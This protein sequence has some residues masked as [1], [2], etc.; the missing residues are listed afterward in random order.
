MVH[1][2]A[3]RMR[4]AGRGG[5]IINISATGSRSVSSARNFHIVPYNVSKAGLD[6]FT[7]Y[8]AVALGDS[9]VRVN[10]IILGPTH[11]DLDKQLPPG[12]V[13]RIETTILTRRFGEPL[14]VGGL[15]VYMASP[16][17]AMVTGANWTFDGGMLCVT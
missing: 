13:E 8:L 6:I 9:G 7:R 2:I 10:S 4:D 16:A 3:P 11:S 15:C 5:T 1:E 17:G 12:S 14:E